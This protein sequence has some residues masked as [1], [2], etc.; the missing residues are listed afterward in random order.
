VVYIPADHNQAQYKARF[1]AAAAAAG[2]AGCA[3]WLALPL[4][5]RGAKAMLCH[6]FQVPG[7][8]VFSS[9]SFFFFLLLAPPP[10]WPDRLY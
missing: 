5:E 7:E 1:E 6:E 10:P 4:E 9:S 8:R 3:R 2:P